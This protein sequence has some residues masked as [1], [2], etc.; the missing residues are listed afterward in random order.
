M[1]ATSTTQTGP[2]NGPPPPHVF[3]AIVE[4]HGTCGLLRFLGSLLGFTAVH[5]LIRL[6]L[7]V[8]LRLTD[9]LLA[10]FSPPAAAGFPGRPI[11][12]PAAY[13]G[14]TA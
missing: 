13:G 8:L 7:L 2:A 10:R 1:V 6:P 12:T 4:H 5:T 9:G 3:D 14:G 11:T